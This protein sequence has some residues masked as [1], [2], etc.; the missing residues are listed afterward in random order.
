MAKNNAKLKSKWTIG[1]VYAAVIAV[2]AAVAVY[3][4]LYYAMPYEMIVYDANNQPVTV[5]FTDDLYNRSMQLMMV[6]IIFPVISYLWMYGSYAKLVSEF[7][8]EKE[9]IKRDNRPWIR[10]LILQL[11]L[12][13]VWGFVSVTMISLG[14][15]LDSSLFA[16][17]IMLK[18]FYTVYGIAILVDTVL[19]LVGKQLFK[20][21]AVQRA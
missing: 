16:D 4:G 13:L 20:P 18:Q 17:S 11:L 9:K 12:L 7:P 10:S 1:V 5:L 14:L 15:G 21:D 19:F 8:H 2:L 3:I 6:S